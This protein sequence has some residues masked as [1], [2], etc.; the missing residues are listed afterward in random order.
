VNSPRYAKLYRFSLWF[1]ISFM[2][3]IGLSVMPP[4]LQQ[5]GWRTAAIAQSANP[6]QLV[7]QGVDHYEAGAFPSAIASWQSALE[8]YQ[9][10]GNR[11]NEAIVLE[12]LARAYQ[13]LGQVN[14]AVGYWEQVILL[15]RQLG[16]RQRVGRLLTEQAQSFSRAGQYRQA[17]TLLCAPISLISQGC[18]SESALAIARE[19]GDREGEAA[20]LGSLGDAYRLRGEYKQA[21]EQYLQPAL[22]LAESLDH[23]PYRAAALNSL[24]NAHVSL[25][26]MNYRRVNSARLIGEEVE[27]IEQFQQLATDHDQ[28]AITYFEGS[29]ELAQSQN[30][31]Q[32]QMRSLLNAIPSYYRL[33]QSDRAIARRQIALS[34]LETLPNSQTKV[35]TAIDLARLLQ[36][37]YTP[38]ASFTASQCFASEVKS[39]A[40]SLLEQAVAVAQQIQDRRAESFALGELGHLY[41]C[42]GVYIK[43]LEYTQQA[44]WAADQ[45]LLAQDSLYLWEWQTGRILKAQKREQEA[46]AA[47]E[48]AVATLEKIRDDILTANRDLQ[49]DFRDTV[50]PIYQGLVALKLDQSSLSTSTQLSDRNQTISEVLGTVNSLRLAELQNYFGNDC[51]LTAVNEA[52]VDRV[53]ATH[54][55]VFSSIILEDRTAMILSLPN[56]R[57]QFNWIEVDRGTLTQTINDFRLGLESYFDEYDRTPA[58]QVYQ[59]L[60]APFETALTEAEIDTLIFV[61][62]GILRSVPM[63]ALHDGE[64]FLIEKYAIATT[65]TLTLANVTPLNR[66]KLRALA[67]GVTE[68]ATVNGQVFEALPN[69]PLEINEVQSLLPDSTSLLNDEFTSDRLRQE[70]TENDYSIIHIATHGE[71]GAEPNDNF[72][73]TGKNQSLTISQL[74]DILRSVGSTEQIELLAL[75]A[76][77]TAIGDDRAALGLAGVAVQAGVKSA[78]ASLWLIEDAATA[79]IADQFYRNLLNPNMSRAEALRAAQLKLLKESEQYQHPA[80]WAPYILIGNWQ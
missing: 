64:Q 80:F 50:E 6:S 75:T 25:A 72:L 27:Q 15:Y 2:L 35:Y 5:I 70:L 52:R 13:Q 62:D 73:V 78:L 58:Q 77:N 14:Q 57:R 24:G 42:D 34:L 53:D 41:E 61:Q 19:L 8:I 71:F 30:D 17:I 69:V 63:A 29:L 7:Q 59:W 66:R 67:L 74:E 56:E 60:I 9:T 26:Q 11:V 43:A 28:Q 48:Q 32:S 33:G 37:L 36:P 18:E 45:D 3:C 1:V 23:L 76:C 16:D 65:P 79:E 20:A 68:N 4:Q 38:D 51:V 10:S 46:I 31:P 49:Y 55:A 54:T 21:I 47:Y 40:K 12:N 22:T 39:E 44:R